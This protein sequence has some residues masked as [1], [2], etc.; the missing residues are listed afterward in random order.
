M[1]SQ[2]PH[3]LQVQSGRQLRAE[4][5][6][7][8]RNRREDGICETEQVVTQKKPQLLE[9][10]TWEHVHLIQ[11]INPEGQPHSLPIPNR[12][13]NTAGMGKERNLERPNLFW[14]ENEGKVNSRGKM[15]VLYGYCHWRLDCEAWSIV[16]DSEMQSGSRVGSYGK[17]FWPSD[18]CWIL[19]TWD[20]HCCPLWLS[21]CELWSQHRNEFYQYFCNEGKTC[22]GQVGHWIPEY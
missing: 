5:K 22:L 4:E 14:K 2:I 18:K 13:S 7:E 16:L 15:V 20:T 12:A 9:D 11:V 21:K 17:T 8:K 1:P 6:Q 19:K 10:L 3:T